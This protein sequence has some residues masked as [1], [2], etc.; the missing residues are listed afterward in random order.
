[1]SNYEIRLRK[2]EK[3]NLFIVDNTPRIWSDTLQ[4][5][6]RHWVKT[7]TG[8]LRKCALFEEKFVKLEK[9]TKN[10]CKE[11]LDLLS[12][13]IGKDGYTLVED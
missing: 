6:Y 5:Y 4:T 11:L 8:W 12:K 2:D 3:G 10:E 1:M 9:A 7:D 13:E